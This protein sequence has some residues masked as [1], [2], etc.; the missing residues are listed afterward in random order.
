MRNN[1]SAYETH[2]YTWKT[3]WEYY[4]SVKIGPQDPKIECNGAEMPVGTN[5]YMALHRVR[6][7]DST[8]VVWADAICINQKDVHERSQQIA[9]M[10]DIFRNAYSVL[11]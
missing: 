6:R 5:L 3:G 9:T 11:V 4:G 8:R 1:R 7:E 2:S 10:G